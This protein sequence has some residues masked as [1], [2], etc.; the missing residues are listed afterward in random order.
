[1]SIEEAMTV[2]ERRKYLHKSS[3]RR[4]SYNFLHSQAPRPME[5]AG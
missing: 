1:M 5:Q 3:L 4:Q 2:N